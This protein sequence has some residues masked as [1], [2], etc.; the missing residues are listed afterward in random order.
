[1]AQTQ[2]PES[3]LR[4]KESA[5]HMEAVEVKA[6][7]AWLHYLRAK[8]AFLDDQQRRLRAEVE[9]Q[10]SLLEQADKENNVL[11]RE[12]AALVEETA[13]LRRALQ[14]E[15]L[16]S[17][18][19]ERKN[20]AAYLELERIRKEL[21]GV[22]D[23]VYQDNILRSKDSRVSDTQREKEALLRDLQ[24][25]KMEANEKA[26]KAAVDLDFA[27][28]AVEESRGHMTR[29]QEQIQNLM[30]QCKAKDKEVGN[31]TGLLQLETTRREHA[32]KILEQ[33]R[34][35][36]QELQQEQWKLR[37]EHEKSKAS[38][39]DLE[40]RVD[41]G[42]KVHS[43]L[44]DAVKN[45]ESTIKTL[46]ERDRASTHG[47]PRAEFMKM[48]TRLEDIIQQ[49]DQTITGLEKRVLDLDT[50][51]ANTN[52]IL[53]ESPY[54]FEEKQKM[55]I[56]MEQYHKHH[57][58]LNEQ[59]D[60]RT[61][62]V[63][64]LRQQIRSF[65]VKGG[66]ANLENQ[67]AMTEQLKTL[68]LQRKE[69]DATKEALAEATGELSARKLET[70]RVL[71]QLRDIMNREEILSKDPEQ[72][73]HRDGGVRYKRNQKQMKEMV[74]SYEGEVSRLSTRLV[75]LEQSALENFDAQISSILLNRKAHEKSGVEG[76]DDGDGG[77]WTNKMVS[78]I[79]LQEQHQQQQRERE[80]QAQAGDLVD[81]AHGSPG[82]VKREHLGEV[83]DVTI[84][85]G[86][87][88][89]DKDK[90]GGAD[91]ASVGVFVANSYVVMALK[92]GGA[93]ERAGVIRPGDFLQSVDGVSTS[94][95]TPKQVAEA[96]QGAP[97]SS[98]QLT[99]FRMLDT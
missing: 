87:T 53:F 7:G 47:I 28:K 43:T 69:L 40:G 17:H 76:G 16:K 99:L 31:L 26:A 65:I 60:W 98:C 84:T 27:N 81:D 68:T 44:K 50:T 54:T 94:T 34:T 24:K 74:D 12:V 39:R 9:K 95:L 73:L 14:G 15:E 29:Q 88:Q 1:V 72:W 71:E 92:E 8:M 49:R 32:D 46:R 93:A 10:N 2:D 5:Q 91:V 52:R 19:L 21:A 57:A 82:K 51:I 41:S 79:A 4:N 35:E 18:E 20:T 55:E 89:H 83:V 64:S 30:D 59:L 75:T 38:I 37:L 25:L 61:A 58:S 85:R 78:A 23:E 77:V 48:Q 22:R 90:D 36:Q 6:G 70:L 97:D 67:T 45:H 33:M 66:A 96:L 13:N 11:K 86:Q 42:K 3:P 62:E 63:V 56:Q 80:H